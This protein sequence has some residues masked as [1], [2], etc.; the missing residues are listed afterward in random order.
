MLVLKGLIKRNRCPNIVPRSST[1]KPHQGHDHRKNNKTKTT[2]ASGGGVVGEEFRTKDSLG[3]N[4][5]LGGDLDSSFLFPVPLTKWLEDMDVD[6]TA[7]SCG[8]YKCLLPSRTNRQHLDEHGRRTTSIGNGDGNSNVQLPTQFAYLVAPDVMEKRFWSAVVDGWELAS[9]LSKKFSIQ[10]FLRAAPRRLK[11]T[12]DLSARL[13]N[14][15]RAGHGGRQIPNKFDNLSPE[16]DLIVQPIEVAPDNALLF[17]CVGNV[18]ELLPSNKNTKLPPLSTASERLEFEN[19]LRFE[20]EAT[21][22]LMNS[23]EGRCL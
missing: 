23:T 15:K 8:L 14:A 9:E 17:K 12:E 7:I 3:S 10:H 5:K 19:R 21:V 1:E 2:A 4:A 20:L 22:A 11:C 18:V 16:I 6:A 13:Q